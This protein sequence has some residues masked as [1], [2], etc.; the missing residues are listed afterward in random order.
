VVD[1]KRS[2]R[3]TT[4]AALVQEQMRDYASREEGQKERDR[5]E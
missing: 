1:V 2:H 5:G 3:Q 4:A